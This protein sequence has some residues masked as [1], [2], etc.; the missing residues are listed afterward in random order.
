MEKVCG[1]WA[2]GTDPQI[3]IDAIQGLFDSGIKLVNIHA[4]QM[5]QQRAIDFYGAKVLPALR[6]PKG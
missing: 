2:I 3:H 1:E 6:H 5:D 4:G